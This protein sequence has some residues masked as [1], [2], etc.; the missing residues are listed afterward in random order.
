MNVET[1][2]DMLGVEFSTLSEKRV[3]LLDTYID[4]G[5]EYI[6]NYFKKK[7]CNI[8][9]SKDDVSPSFK[10]AIKLNFL[11]HKSF[12]SGIYKAVFDGRNEMDVFNR[13]KIN[14]LWASNRKI[15]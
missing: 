5:I 7:D 10:I 1:L 13:F 2:A 4:A 11:P 15:L 8:V 6:N 9:I 12:N 14:C 3:K